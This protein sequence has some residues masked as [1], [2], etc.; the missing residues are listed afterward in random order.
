MDCRESKISSS[1]GFLAVVLL[2]NWYGCYLSSWE[3]FRP[4][5]WRT[6]E[7]IKLLE[8]WELLF[9]ISN[10]DDVSYWVSEGKGDF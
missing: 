9:F 6:K 2:I 10:G 7:N 5:S 4:I 8:P 1:S 3:I